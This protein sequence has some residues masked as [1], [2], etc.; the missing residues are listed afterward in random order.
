VLTRPGCN[1]RQFHHG[2]AAKP[3]GDAE[4][5]LAPAYSQI[6]RKGQQEKHHSDL[7]DSDAALGGRNGQ[8]PRYIVRRVRGNRYHACH[9]QHYQTRP[10]EQHRAQVTQGMEG[11]EH[12]EKRFVNYLETQSYADCSTKPGKV[13]NGRGVVPVS[14][15]NHGEAENLGDD[16]GKEKLEFAVLAAAE[17]SD[18]DHRLE[19]GMSD[20]KSVIKDSNF[21]AH[22]QVSWRSQQS[23]RPD[24]IQLRLVRTA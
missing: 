19:N 3:Q 9:Q 1:Q 11:P 16:V 14:R 2:E 22:R 18:G 24:Q 21:F 20:P 12:I 15:K 7:N 23:W 10:L 17:H 13:K 8:H 6:A 4:A 5:V